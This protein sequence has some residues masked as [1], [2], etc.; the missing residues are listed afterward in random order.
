MKGEKQT[1]PQVFISY[2][3]SSTPHI[4]KVLSL[5]TRLTSDGIDVKFDRWD[6]AEGRD[7]LV[8]MEQMV[9]SP[10]ISKVLM[11][12]DKLYAEKA[13]ERKGGV[14]RSLCFQSLSRIRQSRPNGSQHN[15]Q[16]LF[17]PKEMER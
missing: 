7:K 1:A 10:S 14:G 9:N 3:W 5:A 15:S 13:N 6:L 4:E 8:F 12:L 11:I 2:S 16:F 17:S